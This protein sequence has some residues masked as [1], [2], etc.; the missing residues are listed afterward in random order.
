MSNFWQKFEDFQREF[1]TLRK[2]KI[3][4][5]KAEDPFHFE[6][7]KAEFKLEQVCRQ[8]KKAGDV[9]FEVFFGEVFLS[10]VFLC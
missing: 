1:S 9:L 4:L 10:E 3:S 7:K 8:K 6:L 5:E 2:E